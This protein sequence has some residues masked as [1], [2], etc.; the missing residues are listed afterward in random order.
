[1][2][3]V[4]ILIGIVLSIGL[5]AQVGRYPVSNTAHISAAPSNMVQNGTFDGGTYWDVTAS[6]WSIAGGVAVYDGAATQTMFQTDADLIGSMENNTNY[7]I[8]FTLGR[9]SGAANPYMGIYNAATN[10]TYVALQ[11]MTIGE[12]NFSFTTPADVVAGGFRIFSDTYTITI[13]NVVLTLDE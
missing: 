11:T 9:T 6:S 1:M 13:D 2:K 4:L 3:K 7:T 5:N 8:T 12:K 10:A